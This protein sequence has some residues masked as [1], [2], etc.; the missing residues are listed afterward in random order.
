MGGWGGD[1]RGV[2]WEGGGEGWGGDVPAL[3]FERAS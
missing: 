2:G 3:A 1:G